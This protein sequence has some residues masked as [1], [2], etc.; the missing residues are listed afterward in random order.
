MK[1]LIT[2]APGEDGFWITECPAIPGCMTQGR[3]REE[4]A[5]AIREAIAACIEVPAELGLPFTV[6]SRT[7][8]AFAAYS[9]FQDGF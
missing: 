2:L 4:A 7:T 6:Q 8:Q 3:S 9:N 5:D 1:F